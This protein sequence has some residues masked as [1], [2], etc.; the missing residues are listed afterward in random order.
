M[1]GDLKLVYDC[2]DNSFSHIDLILEK[3]GVKPSSV[4]SA[5]TQLEIMGLVQSTSG[6]RYKKI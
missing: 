1:T 2:L 6:K 3:T 4:I 5:L